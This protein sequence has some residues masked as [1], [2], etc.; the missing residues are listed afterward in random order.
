MSETMTAGEIVFHASAAGQNVIFENALWSRTIDAFFDFE[1]LPIQ[2]ED[3]VEGDQRTR[4]LDL[5][6]LNFVNEVDGT[7]LCLIG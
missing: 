4:F 5:L 2:R 1:G 6:R 7:L 3:I